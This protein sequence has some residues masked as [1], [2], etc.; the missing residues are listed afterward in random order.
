MWYHV[1]LILMVE[2][3]TDDMK[4]DLTHPDL[5]L[6]FLPTAIEWDSL[7]YNLYYHAR[8]KVGKEQS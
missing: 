3:N 7:Q 1:L 2:N 5:R 8:I 6:H 4:M